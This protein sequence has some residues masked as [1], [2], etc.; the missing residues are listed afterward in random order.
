MALKSV[1]ESYRDAK[2]A[3]GDPDK[4]PTYVEW[5]IGHGVKVNGSHL[6]AEGR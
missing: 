2:I 3:Y 1:W 6:L 4:S 5:L